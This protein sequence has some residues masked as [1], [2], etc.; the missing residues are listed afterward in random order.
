MTCAA[1]SSARQIDPAAFFQL[2]MNCAE[3]SVGENAGTSG[4]ETGE[5]LGIERGYGALALGFDPPSRK[6]EDRANRD[7][8]P[9]ELGELAGER[10]AAGEK[11]K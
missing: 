3:L 7:G 2:G 4:E 10:G 5:T 9:V 11:Q 6:D 1:T 8:S